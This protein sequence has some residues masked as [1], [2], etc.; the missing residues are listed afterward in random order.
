MLE[1]YG[2][3]QTYLDLMDQCEQLILFLLTELNFGESVVYQGKKIDFKTPWKRLSVNR[4]FSMYTSMT[5][6]QAVTG[7]CFDEILVD[8]IEP[9]MGANPI[10][11]YD[12]PASQAALARLKHGESYLGERFELYIGGLELCNAFSE[13]TDPAEA[14]LR[15][16]AE[17]EKRD[18]SG[19]SVYP[20]PE[21]F[22]AALTDM[23]DA[24]GNALG[25]DRL[26][27]LF[28]DT[29]NIDDVVAFTPEEL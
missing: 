27:M 3:G 23:P 2:R 13:L 8:Q 12:Y 4:A 26:V 14:R 10:F 22:L 19:K 5:L 18:S 28:A 11:L 7:N 20:L 1:W 24:A 9:R 17:R 25:I 29:K 15:F 16:E 21:K 6:N